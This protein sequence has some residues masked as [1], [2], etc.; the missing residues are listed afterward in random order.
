MRAAVRENAVEIEVR[1]TLGSQIPPMASAMVSAVLTH[2]GVPV[3]GAR[4]RLGGSHCGGPLL[5]QVN[6]EVRGTAARVQVAGPT[7]SRAVA[8]AG[9]RL[10]AQLRRLVGRWEPWPWPDPDRRSLGVPGAASVVRH[11][12][13]HLRTALPCQAATTMHAMDYDA[14]LFHDR[15]SDEDAVVY[16]AGPSGVRLARQHTM[17]PPRPTATALTVNPH[18]VPT[19][20]GDQ[21]TER[22]T[23][24]WLPF[25]F[26]TDRPTGRGHLLYRRY[27][28]HLGLVTPR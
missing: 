15:E 24:G 11:K 22:L 3:D 13:V 8:A 5:V 17:R 19:L 28:G 7:P 27:D 18:R 6:V 16:R 26:Y 21:A 14:H 1:G 25:L 10:D 4:V 9:A 23:E 12:D 20:T 2:H